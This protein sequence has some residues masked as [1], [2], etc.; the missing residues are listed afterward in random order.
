MFH[1]SLLDSSVSPNSVNNF[2]LNFK[3]SLQVDQD[4]CSLL[5]WAAINNRIDV[6]KNFNF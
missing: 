2:I 4:D 3:L 5:H 1:F 6:F